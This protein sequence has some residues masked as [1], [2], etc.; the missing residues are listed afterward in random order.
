LANSLRPRIFS[1][2][3]LLEDGLA[4]ATAAYQARSSGNSLGPVVALSPKLAKELCGS[5]PVGLTVL[6]GPP[7]SGKSAFAQQLAAEA[8]CPAMIATFEMPPI[9]LLRRH[10]ARVTNEYI[11]KFRSGE[12]HPDEWLRLMRSAA[13]KAPK[14]SILDG[15]CTSVSPADLLEAVEVSRQDDPYGVLIIDS[16]SAWARSN[17]SVG[18]TEYERTTLAISALQ[19]IA[20]KTR[21]AVVVVAEQNRAGR[22]EP[23]QDA[24]AGSRAFEYGAE[25]MIALSRD[26][27]AIPDANSAIIIELELVKNRL[28][29]QG[30][31]I[32]MRFEG[33]FMRFSEG[34]PVV[35]D[36]S[37]RGRRSA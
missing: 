2:A 34:E 17:E 19:Q 13:A 36:M 20:Q 11:S 25:V 29:V 1:F 5:L 37:R 28:G 18:A 24:A 30:R 21:T 6:H 8:G 14:L 16:A 4:Q 31:K 12:L 15:T 27:D 26:P 35:I 9:E 33:G 7:G 3:D 10:A 22:N 23:R 32:P